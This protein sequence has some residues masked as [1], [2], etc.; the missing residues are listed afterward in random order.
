MVRINIRLDKFD[1]LYGIGIGMVVYVD[2]SGFELDEEDNMEEYQELLKRNHIVRLSIVTEKI[3]DDVLNLINI[4]LF[5]NPNL[6]IWLHTNQLYED[7]SNDKSIV[8]KFVDYFEEESGRIIDVQQTL[9]KNKIIE[10]KY[11]E[12]LNDIG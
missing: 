10:L 1:I 7:V 11:Y 6:R 5:I 9:I 8:I 3:S 12:A 4:S 2:D